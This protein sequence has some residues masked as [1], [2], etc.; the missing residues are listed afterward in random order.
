MFELTVKIIFR[1]VAALKRRD[2]AARVMCDIVNRMRWLTSR[3]RRYQRSLEQF[4]QM[5]MLRPLQAL[6]QFFFFC[7]LWRFDS[8]FDRE[9]GHRLLQDICLSGQR[10]GG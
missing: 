5:R 10:F 4:D 3:R 8:F 1:A 2:R 7:A 9:K 6:Q